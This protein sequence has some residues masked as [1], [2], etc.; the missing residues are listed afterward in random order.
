MTTVALRLQGEGVDLA[1]YGVI[2]VVDDMEDVRQALGYARI[3]LIGGSYGGAVAYA[4]CIRYP[5]SIHRCIITEGA[6]PFNVGMAEPDGVDSKLH[7]LNELWQMS[8]RVV[9]VGDIVTTIRDVMATL[10]RTWHGITIDPGRIKLMIY[11]GLYTYETTAQFCD[12]FVAAE[13]G[14][15]SGLA[16]MHVMWEQ[17]VDWF[18]WGDMCAKLYSTRTGPERDY[19]QELDPPG[20]IIGAPLAKLGWAPTK[21]VRW[22]TKPLPE[23][24]RVWQH[25]GV[26]TLLIYGSRESAPYTHLPYFD[27]GHLVV[28]GDA[29]HM[30]VTAE[31]PEASEHLQ[32]R[33]LM[34][35]L[36]DKSQFRD[37]PPVPKNFIPQQSFQSMAKTMIK[38]NSE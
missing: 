34:D 13:Q 21:Y 31:Q 29:G 2:D 14:D 9:E 3:N 37:A 26:E 32:A 35:G 20:S 36:I 19:E 1:G 12:A 28:M 6:F 5:E 11:M 18:N 16:F 23:K 24:H 27:K 4:Y 10:P 33:F 38:A 25:S 15:Y 17:I 22:P 30:D 7:R 8:E